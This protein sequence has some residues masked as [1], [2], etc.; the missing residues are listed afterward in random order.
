MRGEGRLRYR[1][2]PATPG[3]RVNSQLPGNLAPREYAS[4]LQA[5]NDGR[6]IAPHRDAAEVRPLGATRRNQAVAD[7]TGRADVA[8]EARVRRANLLDLVHRRQVDL[9]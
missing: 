1:G 6:E 3:A 5:A 8:A 4:T 9:L 7:D 2:A